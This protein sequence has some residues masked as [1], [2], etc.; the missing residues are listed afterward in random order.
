MSSL[1]LAALAAIAGGLLRVLGA[2][3]PGTDLPA[4]SLQQFYFMTDFLLLLGVFGLYGENAAKLGLTGAAGLAVFVFGI[5]VVRSP[6]VS[7]LGAGG[8]QTGAAI[9]LLG[10]TLLGAMMLARKTARLAPLLW[11]A[12]LAAGMSAATGFLAGAT[13]AVAGILFGAGFVAGGIS[14]LRLA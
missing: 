8:Y 2:F 12:A 11:F 5:L 9:A 14:R 1:K 4:E 3:L 7:F 10:I 6:Q 13:A